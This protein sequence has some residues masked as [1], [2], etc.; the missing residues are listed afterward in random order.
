MARKLTIP[1]LERL[2]ENIHTLNAKAGLHPDTI[3][4]V[5]RKIKLLSDQLNNE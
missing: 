1:E 3:K 5:I 4:D 2:Q